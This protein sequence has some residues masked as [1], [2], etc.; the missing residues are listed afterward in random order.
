MTRD[1]KEDIIMNT[2]RSVIIFALIILVA[3]CIVGAGLALRF[4]SRPSSQVQAPSASTSTVAPPQNAVVSRSSHSSN[5]KQDWVDAA[6]KQFNAENH[7]IAAGRMIVVKATHVGSGSSMTSILEGNTKPTAWS[8]GSNTWVAQINQAWTDRTGKKLITAD[9][10]PTTREPIAIAMWE[11]MA[12][13]LGW[14]DKPISW[15]DL[16]ALSADPQGWAT[17][18]HPEWGDLKFGHGHPDQSNS[19]LLSMIVEVYASAGVTRGLTA[20]Q[21]KSQA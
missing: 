19:G 4:L 16:A 21:V 5:T 8:P 6:I 2:Q 20:D 17:R 13:A 1:S 18:G 10:P 7:K 11:P 3:L 9:C 14:P 15:R 12:R